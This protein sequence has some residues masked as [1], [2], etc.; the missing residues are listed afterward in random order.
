[1]TAGNMAMLAYTDSNSVTD[2]EKVVVAAAEPSQDHAG[3]VNFMATV[4]AVGA[5]FAVRIV[6]DDGEGTK[7]KVAEYEFDP[8][9]NTAL[10]EGFTYDN[11][12]VALGSQVVQAYRV[13]STGPLVLAATPFASD[14][15]HAVTGAYSLDLYAADW[16]LIAFDAGSP[17]KMDISEIITHT[18]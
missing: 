16:V 11:D 8:V 18:V 17:N 3:D 13:I 12:G 2:T 14:T 4:Q 7:P 15:S 6:A 10:L 9:W 1:M 5:G